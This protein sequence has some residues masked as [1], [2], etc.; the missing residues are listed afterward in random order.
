MSRDLTWFQWLRQ[1]L[2]PPDFSVKRLTMKDLEKQWSTKFEQLMRNRLIMG[3]LRY[4]S[5]I[6]RKT[7]SNFKIVK[8]IEHRLKMYESTGNTEHLVDIANLCMVEF[9]CGYHP[10]KHFEA[11]D[12]GHHVSK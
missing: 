2:E 7:T 6:D 5:F 4:G 1:R 12:D 3:T 11:I 10:T 9:V 8:S